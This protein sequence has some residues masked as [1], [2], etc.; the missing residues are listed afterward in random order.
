MA[1]AKIA[2]TAEDKTKAAFASVQGSL[3]GLQ[4]KAVAVSG[5][6]SG[7]GVGVLAGA[8]KQTIDDWDELGKAAQRAGFQ[9]AQS[10]SEFQFAAKLA[11]V[12]AAG[13]EQ[14]VGKLSAK[15][16]DA[17]GG[18]KEAAATFAAMGVKIK[19]ANGQLRDSESVV[20]DLA[21]AFAG[22]KD[23]PEKT[24]LALDLFGKAGKQLIPLLNGGAEGLEKLRAEFRQLHGQ[25]TGDMT[26]A[27]EQ[28]ND[29]ISRLQAAAGGF[30]RELTAGMLPGLVQITE[31]MAV[32]A[33]EGGLLMGVWRGLKEF[34]SIAFGTDAI[35]KATSK[36]KEL[37]AEMNRI[38]GI[39]DQLEAV[40]ARDPENAAAKRRFDN[41]RKQLEGVQK[42]AFKASQA[43]QH[44]LDPLGFNNDASYQAKDARRFG[45][46]TAAPIVPKSGS[47]S[48]S[49]YSKLNKE[50][51]KRIALEQAEFAAGGK[52]M[53]FR[54]YE[55]DMLAKISGETK[56][57]TAS[58]R[59]RLEAKV[60]DVSAQIQ[61]NNLL[62][63]EAKEAHERAVERQ[64]VRNAEYEAG[65]ALVIAEMEAVN[66]RNKVGRESL[67]QLE[68]D[69]RLMTMDNKARE[70]AI[71]MRELERQGVKKGTE[72]W[73]K[74]AE[75]I[76]KAVGDKAAL[77]ENIDR[78]K[79]GWESLDQTAHDV[80]TNIFE[81]GS[82]VF[83]KLGQTL[84]ASLL[85]LLYQMTVRKWVFQIYANVTGGGAGGGLAG[86][87]G[88]AV[89]GIAQSGLSSLLGGGASAAGLG[90]GLLSTLSTAYT[91]GS[92]SVGVM[93]GSIAGGGGVMGG[94]AS[95]LS[96]IPVAGWIAAA[97]VA[98]YSMFGNKGGGPKTESGYAGINGDLNVETKFGDPSGA[99]TISEGIS[100]SYEALA[101]QLGLVNRKLDV[102][103]Y[104]A[105]DTHKNGTAQTL[106]QVTS[107]TYD[108]N[109]RL[110]GIE[111]VARG[112]EAL[113]AALAE[114]TT[115]VIFEALKASDLSEVYKGWLNAVAA[116]AGIGE[117][118]A[119]LDHVAKAS[120][121]K[122][123]LEATL[124]ELTATDLQK[125]TKAREAERAAVDA[126]N[127]ALLE[128][129]YAVQDRKANIEQFNQLMAQTA[130]AE[131]EANRAAKEFLQTIRDMAGQAYDK[132]MADKI[133]AVRQ[134][135]EALAAA[136]SKLQSAFEVQLSTFTPMIEALWSNADRLAEARRS[137]DIGENSGLDE[138]GKYAAIKRAFYTAS[139]A[140][141]PGLVDQYLSAT[142]AR[143][144]TRAGYL[145]EADKAAANLKATEDAARLQAN[146]MAAQINATRALLAPLM[147]IK[148]ILTIEA[149]TMGVQ[150]A[151]ANLSKAQTDLS[152]FQAYI[153]SFDVGTDYVP[154]DMLAMVHRG[155]KIT[156]ASQ[157]IG[158]ASDVAAI[159][160]RLDR[161][162]ALLERVVMDTAQVRSNTQ[163]AID[164]GVPALPAP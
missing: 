1:D 122:K 78:F 85:D 20:T 123:Q 139:A 46:P 120:A 48:E 113:K 36:T 27:A 24:A 52:L 10:I 13:F 151:Q 50:M 160:A 94:V 47:A 159:C 77:Q 31:A 107:S 84:K 140:D 144:G 95:A 111:N 88:T 153:P 131:D 154:R 104:Y 114:E 39:M 158:G 89:N 133:N 11:G 73:D 12:D 57:L 65:K 62:E 37:D 134:A 155:E 157:N 38:R 141:M 146:D 43:L 56:K 87:A 142:K 150:V 143:S 15:M 55:V 19:D 148:E 103:V 106:L 81:G 105:M 28:F 121:E 115:R 33:K 7:I 72:A 59:A 30:T 132:A 93:A 127:L 92:T 6:L 53:E 64:R 83:K 129:I 41:L 54:R 21:R 128:E 45:A 8:I 42:D 117:I 138:P 164:R 70:V 99:K 112:E 49:E 4:T 116:D 102:G 75:L 90:G 119:A 145:L 14:A 149:A 35:G 16:A 161:Q 61:A 118:Q 97:A 98:L 124:F 22:Y 156:K 2:L 152:N 108:R 162:N 96:A 100:S 109:A 3:T 125:L 58:E 23:G 163:E 67:E 69:I 136:R 101:T 79:A 126:S 18:N 137:I 17:A 135:E 34:G 25:I 32:G 68:F 66:N 147:D 26:R 80:F 71:A 51:E 29:N 9:S 130:L 74:Y 44:A 63:A 82:N 86:A 5:A 40:M 76:A 60:K 110:G 91:A